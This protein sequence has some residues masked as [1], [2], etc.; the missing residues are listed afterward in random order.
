MSRTTPTRR[1][2]SAT[3]RT[4]GNSQSYGGLGDSW[5]E[6]AYESDGSLSV[7]SGSD[8]EFNS[9]EA[10]S[11]L[12]DQPTPLPPVTARA[13]S[14]MAQ[15]TPVKTPTS[16]KSL[17]HS[18]SP[19]T[20]QS[21]SSVEPAFIMPSM[22]SS[23]AELQDSSP[24]QQPTMRFRQPLRPSQSQRWNRS[25]R[26]S[27]GS[28][29]TSKRHSTN[30]R[31]FPSEEADSDD[32][33]WL[34]TWYNIVKPTGAYFASILKSVFMALQ[35]PLSAFIVVFLCY[36][37]INATRQSLINTVTSTLAP[38]C[39]I[40]GSSYV[41]PFCSGISTQKVEPP[42]QELVKLQSNFEDVLESSKQGE[43]LPA[44]MKRSESAIRDLRVKVEYSN[45]PSRNEL[46][47]EMDSFVTTARNAVYQLMSFNKRINKATD[48][49]LSTNKFTVQVLNN[50]AGIEE[51]RGSLERFF[52]SINPISTFIFPKPTM[53]ERIFE[54]YVQHSSALEAEI[55]DCISEAKQLISV[56][57][58]LEEQIFNIAKIAGR[59][60]HIVSSNQ[61]E[62][63]AKIWTKLG[64]NG[65]KLRKFTGQVQ[66]LNEVN[67]YRRR[68]LGHVTSTLLK[69]QEISAGLEDLKERV[70]TPG[71]VG[72]QSPFKIDYYI[73]IVDQGVERLNEMRM[74]QKESTRQKLFGGGKGKDGVRELPGE[75]GGSVP[76]VTV[77]VNGN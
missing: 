22:R 57:N 21:N 63:L 60:L 67:L 72:S 38:V 32:G 73:D 70:G 71:V 47:F 7:H 28:A 15:G 77:T 11:E 61:D 30:S 27:I 64:G 14:H 9:S 59:D 6:A 45:I 20:P 66:L 54:T 46:K 18:Q 34:W 26:D 8:P 13:S 33:A 36:Q 4:M 42:F 75:E 39:A 53:Q 43:N 17:R 50:R 29:S 41:I 35:Y 40:P 44:D 65:S 52:S 1:P 23:Y 2:L 56:L 24:L 19:I 55:D 74:V 10:E 51:S 3:P 58:Y 37:A 49:V 31:H 12:S 25:S 16:R 76:A 5:G 69:L 48:S 62:I 68:A